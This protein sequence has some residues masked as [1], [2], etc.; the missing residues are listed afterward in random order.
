MKRHIPVMALIL[1]GALLFLYFGDLGGLPLL[2]PDEGRYTEI[3]REMIASGDFILPR[4]NGVLYFEKPVLTYWLVA[5]AIQVFGLNEFASRFWSALLGLAGLFVLYAL[6]RRCWGRRTALIAVLALATSPLYLA[7]SRLTTTD[8]PLCFFLTAA[9]VCFY[10]GHEAVPDRGGAVLRYLAFASAALAVLSKGLVGIVL[11]VAIAGL[12]VAATRRWHLLKKVPWVTG[13]L[14][15]LAVAAPWHVAASLKNP[16]F[17]WFYFVREHFLRYLTPL[18]DRVE[19]VWFFAP[20]LVWGLLPWVA[21]LPA[22]LAEF[23]AGLRS[24]FRSRDA[25]P[26][27]FLWIWAGAIFLFF[28]VSKS[29]L[30]PYILPAF[31]PLCALAALSADRLLEHSG[32]RLRTNRVSTFL[33]LSIAVLLGG[34]F[35]YAGTGRIE[36]LTPGGAPTAA[37]IA[38]GVALALTAATGL[39][40]FLRGDARRYLVCMTLTACA[41]F[42]GIRSLAP[43]LQSDRSTLR[44]AAYIRPRLGPGEQLYCYRYYPQTLPVY[45]ESTVALASFY[46]EQD[47]GASKLPPAE[48]RT[49]FPTSQEFAEIWK[50]GRRVYCVTDTV[51]VRHLYEDGIEPWYPVID[52][53]QVLLM[54]NLPPEAPGRGSH[55]PR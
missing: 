41:L 18:H 55:V 52:E 14:L 7:L 42:G 31:P 40:L 39:V 16:D 12:Y 27:A 4:L 10:L 1:L 19:P 45:L 34:L 49:R 53:G 47:F 25:S 54:S 11:P 13:T 38:S 26:E 33:T 32:W 8:M 3:P 46:G 48:R 37:A 51:S 28:S 22:A 35:V 15:F 6:V 21:L 5:S 20:V 36:N 29:K 9:V 23:L 24:S 43:H 17:A 44:I 2:E 30:V 50:S